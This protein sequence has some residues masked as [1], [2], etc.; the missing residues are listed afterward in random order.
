MKRRIWILVAVGFAL[1]L[2]WFGIL[3]AR[4]VHYTY[5]RAAAD[6]IREDLRDRMAKER[7][8]DDVTVVGYNV[9]GSFF[10]A[11]D[12]FI[13]TGSVPSSNDLRDLT[14][15]VEAANPPGQLS[16]RTVRVG[17]PWHGREEI[18]RPNGVANGT[19]PSDSETNTTSSTPWP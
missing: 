13:L 9:F 2:S 1:F 8:F 19:Q 18:G 3:I 15:I 16:L 12:H 11:S 6:A 4:E 17:P 7:R 10:H 5:N 14:A